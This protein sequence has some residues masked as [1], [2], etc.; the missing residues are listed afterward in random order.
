[1]PGRDGT[2]PAGTGAMTGRGVGFCIGAGFGL[3][4]GLGTACR[5]GF[6]RGFRRFA[7]R[8]QISPENRKKILQAQMDALKNRLS[9]IDSQMNRL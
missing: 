3:G 5:R 2:G 6:G 4:Q 9:V 7:V 1:M 8:D